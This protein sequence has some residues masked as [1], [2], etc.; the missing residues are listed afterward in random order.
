MEDRKA[1]CSCNRGTTGR[2]V[3]SGGGRWGVELHQFVM[4]AA[5]GMAAWAGAP[6]SLPRDHLSKRDCITRHV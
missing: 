1:D 4:R 2:E 3:R 6:T 5:E